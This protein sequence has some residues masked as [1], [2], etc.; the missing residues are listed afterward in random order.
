MIF[1][2][3]LSI[4]LH[5]GL[6]ILRGVKLMN[7]RID[8][9]LHNVSNAFYNDLARGYTLSMC[10][11]RQKNFF[12]DLGI[13]LVN[14]GEESGRLEEIASELANYYEKQYKLKKFI[15][16]ATIYPM[17]LLTASICVLL[18]FIFYVLP[19]LTTTYSSM[20]I[21]PQGLLVGILKVQVFFHEHKTLLLFIFLTGLIITIQSKEN[22]VN[23]S[24]KTPILCKLYFLVL[25][26]RF[27]KLMSLLL[28]SGISI[29]NA[30]AITTKVI[31]DSECRRRLLLFQERLKSGSDI[32]TASTSLTGW[33]SP[34][35]IE[36]ISIGAVTG[37][38][39]KMLSEAAF[40][41]E[42][43]LQNRLD[44]LK[45]IISPLLLLITAI[46]TAGIIIS[47]VGP[48][49]NLISALPDQI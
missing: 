6:P 37:Y 14:A 41:G 20:N 36:L 39:P 46:I 29:T 18:F 26:I 48:L 45:E 44:Q 9:K 2:K 40:I 25:E 11:R 35:A 42:Q 12:G 30:V 28:N 7:M 10:V 34:L 33:I 1:Y 43:D 19:I 23:Q 17:F 3:Q 8:K 32:H 13:M 4:I 21:E 22:L 49:F 16:K 47:V 27:C 38:L 31:S 24:K 5:S 15:L